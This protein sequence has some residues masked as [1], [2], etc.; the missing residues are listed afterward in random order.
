MSA[1]GGLHDQTLRALDDLQQKAVLA[2]RGPNPERSSRIDPDTLAIETRRGEEAGLKLHG[3]LEK[4]LDLLAELVSHSPR[5]P[6]NPIFVLPVDDF[7]LAPT[8]SLEL[9]RLMRIQEMMGKIEFQRNAARDWEKRVSLADFLCLDTQP[10]TD[11]YF[12][13]QW[14]TR[15]RLRPTS[16]VVGTGTA[17]RRPPVMPSGDTVIAFPAR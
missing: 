14:L 2:W 10:F 7:D 5:G 3:Q 1:T 6:Q 11:G 12:G 16:G 8:R 4:A 15:L 17:E 13:A 9:L